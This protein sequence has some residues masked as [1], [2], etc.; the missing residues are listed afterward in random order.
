MPRTALVGREVGGGVGGCVEN[1]EGPDVAPFCSAACGCHATGS[2]ESQA[3]FAGHDFRTCYRSETGSP[4]ADR[5]I[6]SYRSALLLSAALKWVLPDLCSC[7]SCS[8]P[9]G[10]PTGLKV[11]LNGLLLQQGNVI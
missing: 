4:S 6:K 1:W 7:C 3:D 5:T 11:Q 10:L 8:L 9:N 2:A